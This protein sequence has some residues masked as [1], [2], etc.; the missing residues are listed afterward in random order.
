VSSAPLPDGSIE[1]G[2]DGVLQPLVG[3]RDHQPNPTQPR[4]PLTV[5]P[6]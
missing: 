1:D 2:G 4:A 5:I 6:R 3:V